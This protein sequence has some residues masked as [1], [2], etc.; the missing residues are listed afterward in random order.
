MVVAFSFLSLQESKANVRKKD[1]T[2]KLSLRL[3]IT[4]LYLA[5]VERNYYIQDFFYRKVLKLLLNLFCTFIKQLS[6]TKEW[7]GKG[8]KCFRPF[9]IKLLIIVQVF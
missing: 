7:Q 5:D 1:D 4:I 2:R 8:S 3:A 6:F 9:R